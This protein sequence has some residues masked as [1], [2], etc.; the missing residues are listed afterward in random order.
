MAPQTTAAASPNSSST[1]PQSFGLTI[2]ALRLFYGNKNAACIW[3][4]QAH[5]TMLPMPASAV[6]AGHT[7][8]AELAAG[9][10]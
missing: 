3:V 1:Q 9:C 5:A 8:G 7:S 4:T 6:P 10:R 2:P